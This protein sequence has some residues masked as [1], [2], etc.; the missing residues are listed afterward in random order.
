M[1]AYKR[2]QSSELKRIEKKEQNKQR[3][4]P[5]KYMNGMQKPRIF[6]QPVSKDRRIL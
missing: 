2:N 4:E 5:D 6:K 3:K 1:E